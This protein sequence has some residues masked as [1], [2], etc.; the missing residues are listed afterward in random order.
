MSDPVKPT[1]LV[2]DPDHDFLDS[3]KKLGDTRP[4]NM[5]CV[6]YSTRERDPIES[7][8]TKHFPDIVI[9]NLDQDSELDFGSPISEIREIPLTASPIILGTTKQDSV[10]FKQKA[11]NLGVDDYL[12]RPF[13]PIDIWLRLDVLLRIRRLQKQLDHATRKL[14]FV[15]VQLAESNRKLEEMTLTDE[16][17]GLYNMRF[18]LQFLEKQFDLSARYDR[19]FSI[20]MVDLDHFKNVNDSND[21]LVGSAA[22][23]AVGGVI[24]VTSRK[25][26][27][28][29][30][31]G[32]DEYI[33]AL[34]EADQTAAKLA[35]ER[36]RKAISECELTGSDGH[37]FTITASIGATTFNKMIHKNYLDVVKDADAAMY[38][39]KQMG[40]NRVYLYDGITGDYD[41]S[42]SSVLTEIKKAKKVSRG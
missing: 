8:I 32:G 35:G 12:I 2:L 28:K 18:M 26:D 15:N 16:L 31:Y 37:K 41:S 23:K 25:S 27:I 42:Q 24:E 21:H 40:R 29:A 3:M 10:S 14:S 11:Y 39:A 5:V 7:L 22:I 33:I 20:M 4:I 34:P 19:A 17:T 30:R 13:T 6:P 9:M 36:L 1:V 38:R